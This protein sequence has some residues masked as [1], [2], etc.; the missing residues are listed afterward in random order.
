MWWEPSL[1][2]SQHHHHP[3]FK[4][5]IFIVLLFGQSFP[6]LLFFLVQVF[7]LFVLC[8]PSARF[9]DELRC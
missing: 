3:F 9:S 7:D 2:I 6:P 1:A 4:K 5:G 8:V